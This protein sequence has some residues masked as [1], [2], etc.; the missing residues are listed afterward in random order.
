M[1]LKE[2]ITTATPDVFGSLRFSPVKRAINQASLPII[3]PRVEC[4][5]PHDRFLGLS[6]QRSLA[7]TSTDYV[8]VVASF[9]EA[10]T[11]ARAYIQILNLNPN[12]A[13]Q[14]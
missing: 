12:L 5:R 11:E 6:N 2:S 9:T 1:W 8:L 14:V 13:A 4:S 10:L 7:S 3:V